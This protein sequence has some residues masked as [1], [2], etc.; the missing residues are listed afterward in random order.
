MIRQFSIRCLLQRKMRIC[1]QR[2]IRITTLNER[3]SGGISP[4]LALSKS[5][6]GSG[7]YSLHS[8]ALRKCKPPFLYSFLQ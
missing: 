1:L 2:H 5:G 8:P 3:V 4:T 7:Q 6:Y